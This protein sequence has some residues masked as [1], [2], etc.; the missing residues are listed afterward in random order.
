MPSPPVL[1]SI[2]RVL[3][4][5]PE[6]LLSGRIGLLE[7]VDFARAPQA[8]K[9]EAAFLEFQALAGIEERLAIDPP[10]AP[11]AA[12]QLPR[13]AA[14]CQRDIEVLAGHLRKLCQEGTAPVSSMQSLVERIGIRVIEAEMPERFS[15]R[16]YHARPWQQGPVHP[17]V[18]LAAGACCEWK[19]LALAAELG[20]RVVQW[21][22]NDCGRAD[23]ISQRFGSAFLVPADSLR[24]EVGVRRKWISRREVLELKAEYGLPAHVLLVR[25]RET[26]VLSRRACDRVLRGYARSWRKLEPEPT[27]RGGAAFPERSRRSRLVWRAL[28]EDRIPPERAAELLRVRV[29][30]IK[31]EMQEAASWCEQIP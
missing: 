27:F 31:A 30:D 19:R 11:Q 13:A 24:H 14:R 15:G 20:R 5:H 21:K 25:L 23:R 10:G 1:D 2:I 16:V 18:L 7:A 22:G 12:G 28:A 26:G 17:V 29:Q 8:S 4:V 9:Q 3:D 6:F